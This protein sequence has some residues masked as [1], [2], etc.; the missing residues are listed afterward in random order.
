MPEEA[1]RSIAV[2]LT[3]W[4]E[5]LVRLREQHRAGPDG[6][7]LGCTSQVHSAPRWPCALAT[8]AAMAPDRPVD[9]VARMRAR[10]PM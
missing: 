5:V 8:I 6:R 1:F 9:Q 7:C 3:A 4:P 2:S 10:R